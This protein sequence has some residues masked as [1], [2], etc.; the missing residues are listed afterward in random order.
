MSKKQFN[1]IAE[2]FHSY[3]WKTPSKFIPLAKRY[4]FTEQQAK[5]HLASI[6]HDVKV[7]KAKYIPIV[8]KH[9]NIFQMDTFI[10]SKA[11]ANTWSSSKHKGG[12]N[13]LMFININT[14]KA[15]AYP[16]HGKSSK[17]VLNALQQFIKD[18]PNVYS[19]TSDQDAAYLT[20]D[21]LEFINSHNIR[22]RTT[23]DNNHNVLG[24]INRFMRTIRDLIGEN[25]YIDENEMNNLIDAYNNSPHR[26]L[27][28][29]A[30][31]DITDQDEQNY[32]QTKSINNPYDFKHG[33]KVRVVLEP[34]P[35]S[36][37]RNRV[38]KEAYLIDSKSGNQF[39]IKAKDDSVDKYPGYR[40]IKTSNNNLANTIKNGKRGAVDK[41][42]SYDEKKNKYKVQYEGGVQD[43][44]P[45]K[46][47]REGNPARLSTLELEYWSKQKSL[48]DN[49]K[50]WT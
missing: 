3:P 17:E 11:S 22:Y 39:L 5:Q 7:P 18:V 49:I 10:N 25:R 12:L 35:L 23:E 47:L 26:S 2:L 45:A 28:N 14:R 50:K 4:G 13:Y 19:L 16:M 40:L 36:K 15:Y 8:S 1:T 38:S 6:I 21:V 24:I 37:K 44:I 32:I 9:P 33:D 46:N 43:S 20:N 29:K 41:I 34:N 30:P 31:N 42:I 27:D 48:P